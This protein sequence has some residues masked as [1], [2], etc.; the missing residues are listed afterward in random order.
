MVAR[1]RQ[2]KEENNKLIRDFAKRE[3]LNINKCDKQCQT[4]EFKQRGGFEIEEVVESNIKNL[5]KFYTGLTYARFLMLLSF[6][7][8][9]DCANPISYPQKRKETNVKKFPLSQQVFM[10]LCRLRTGLHV[11]DLAFRFNVK[12]PT[13]S[14]VLIG[15]A[16]YMYVR[17]GSL[18]YWP[19]RN[20]IIENMPENYKADFPTCLA[21]LDCTELKCEKPSSL[22]V[23]SQC[24]SDY[25]S[26]NTLKSLVVCD[27]RG[28][29]MFVSDLFSGSISDNEIC[30][31]SG[32]YDF[33]PDLKERGFIVAGDALMAD[34]GFRIE[35]ILSE[36]DINLNIPPFASSGKPLSESEVNMTKKIAAHRIHVERAINKIKCF[37]LLRRKIPVS[38]FHCINENWFVAAILTNFQDTLVKL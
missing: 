31:Q 10:Y 38:L 20:V 22:Q 18:S 21:I 3:L 17:L 36:F 28:S 9:S 24:F 29:V 6:L 23:Q 30:E 27:P 4:E 7:F 8:P 34:K 35:G 2:L 15:V 33:V 13:V 11:K 26:S 37:K 5:F 19:H 25:K 16:K 12:V 14:T 32:F 1:I